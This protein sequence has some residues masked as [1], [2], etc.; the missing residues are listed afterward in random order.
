M[1]ILN[2][3]ISSVEAKEQIDHLLNWS[4]QKTP[5]IGYLGRFVPEKG[6]NLLIKVLDN[7]STPWRA[8]F[9]GGG[10]MESPL[11]KW[12][13]NYPKQVRICTSVKHDQVPQYLNAM[14]ILVAP[15]QTVAN[16]REQF[17]RMLY[18]GFCLWSSC[19]WQ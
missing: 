1:W 10:K 17:G 12:A 3:F 19:H 9:V 18:R 6:L 4:E 13:E 5:V 11:R 14:D 16:W 8:L 7:L 15:S 2:I